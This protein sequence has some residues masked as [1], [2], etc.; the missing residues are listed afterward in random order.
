[1]AFPNDTDYTYAERFGD[2]DAESEL[3]GQ[4]SKHNKYA[5]PIDEAVS[6]DVV[7]ALTSD[8][9]YLEAL[10][11]KMAGDDEFIPAVSASI[12]EE[13][14][15][16]AG[17]DPETD[18]YTESLIAALVADDTYPAA[19]GEAL[20]NDSTFKDALVDWF[21][22]DSD[23]LTA[24]KAQAF[25]IW[26]VDTDVSA[27]VADVV[28]VT[29]TQFNV[30]GAAETG[31]AQ[32]FRLFLYQDQAG[33]AELPAGV[34][35]EATTGMILGPIVAAKEIQVMTD[36]VTGTLVLE[37]TDASDQTVTFDIVLVNDVTGEAYTAT[38]AF[39]DDTP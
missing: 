34:T 6:A 19:L 28:T 10:T 27:E 38:I 22:A 26:W 8:A 4:G 23:F 17:G 12:I 32:V 36:S 25:P 18:T 7:T 1:M 16:D 11:D 21:E 39:V 35:M 33:T 37:F 20:A 9:V 24:I 14:I 2:F 15:T 13:L 31:R 3:G 30:G 5:T 29:F